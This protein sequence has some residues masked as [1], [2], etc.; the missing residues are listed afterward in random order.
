[1][2]FRRSGLRKFNSIWFPTFFFS[3][4]LYSKINRDGVGL[5]KP[6]TETKQKKEK[7]NNSNNS[8]KMR[9]SD[10]CVCSVLSC[11]LYFL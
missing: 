1:M 2:R 4:S 8:F 10:R 5:T 3:A 9:G 6:E 7:G 11:L